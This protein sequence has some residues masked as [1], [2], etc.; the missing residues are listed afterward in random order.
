MWSK[1]IGKTNLRLP[2]AKVLAAWQSE[3][4]GS[5]QTLHQSADV[6]RRVG[7]LVPA[8]LEG[9]ATQLPEGWLVLPRTSGEADSA[10]QAAMREHVEKEQEDALRYVYISP[11]G[12]RFASLNQAMKHNS[13]A[14][15]KR[16]LDKEVANSNL[17]NLDNA[18]GMS[19]QFTSNFEDFMHC[20][21]TSTTCGSIRARNPLMLIP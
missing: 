6:A 1:R 8:L 12:L 17:E 11:E 21:C 20:L 16:R 18:T 10:N 5:L 13:E 14:G 9:K 4:K 15:L 2:F 19:I 7:F 3:F